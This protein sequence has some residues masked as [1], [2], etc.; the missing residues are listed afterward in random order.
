M[1][2]YEVYNAGVGGETAMTIAARQGG[3]NILLDEDVV[4]PADT[5]EVEIKF[6]AYN[7]DGTYAGVVTPRAANTGYW[8]PVTIAGVEGTLS[9]EVNTNVWPRVLNWAKFK[10]NEAGEATTVAKGT[11]VVP[12][13]QQIVEMADINVIYIGENGGWNANNTNKND[14]DADDLV[15]L[16]N[17][18]LA[19]TKRPDKYI[20]IGFHSGN[21]PKT[22]EAM[23]EAFGKHTIL[24]KTYMTTKQALVDGGITPTDA[25][26]TAIAKGSVP[27]SFLTSDGV[28]MTNAGYAA[29]A[30]LVY[31][32]MQELGY[33]D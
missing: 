25:D 10:R 26:L 29:L 18:M 4:I 16:I 30:R 11:E 33:C 20:V 5:S 2:G 27:P 22:D 3:V 28:H 6:S 23:L 17:K 24:P 1:T 21:H 32:K 8:N 7:D 19:K 31:W 13:A 15:V 9:I 12:E 14:N